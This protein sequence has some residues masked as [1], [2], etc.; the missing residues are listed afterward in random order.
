MVI[1]SA[2]TMIG[3]NSETK[4]ILKAKKH[5]GRRMDSGLKQKFPSPIFLTGP[6]RKEQ[7]AEQALGRNK[8]MVGNTK[9]LCQRSV[10]GL[11]FSQTFRT[12]VLTCPEDCMRTRWRQ[13]TDQDKDKSSG[14]GAGVCLW[15]S[16]MARGYM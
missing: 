9:A 15:L 13:L 6:A 3:R 4:G 2:K 14:V 10:L 11:P 8:I 12:W 5:L 1:L 16:S 7:E